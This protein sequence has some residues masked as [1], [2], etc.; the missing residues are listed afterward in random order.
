MAPNLESDIEYGRCLQLHERIVRITQRN[1]GLFTGP[2]TNTFLVGEAALFILEPG[3]DSDQHF[4][5]ITR[6]VGDKPVAG[7]IP[8]HAHPDHW[9]MAT[10]LGQHYDAPTFGFAKSAGYTPDH[11]VHD[12]ETLEAPSVSLLALHTP[13]HTEDHCAY[14]LDDGKTLFSGDIVMDWATTIIAPPEGNLNQY[15]ASLDRL[16]ELGHDTFHPAHGKALTAPMARTQELKEHRLLRTQQAL[17][18]LQTGAQTIP[19][20][21]RTIYA[22]VDPQLH[23]A[24]QFSLHAHLVALEEDGLVRGDTATEVMER[25]WQLV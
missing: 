3:E 4:E 5:A 6:A 12:G 25:E 9:P 15:M 23:P 21:V 14:Q 2:G 18:V 8:T 7:L 22:D 13:G 16:L 1:P 20:M 17:E 11:I 10:R 24:A 19:T